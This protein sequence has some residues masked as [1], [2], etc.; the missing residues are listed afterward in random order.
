MV[1]R[2]GCCSPWP[3]HAQSVFSHVIEGSKIEIPYIW[4]CTRFCLHYE[5]PARVAAALLLTGAELMLFS[6][7]DKLVR[8]SDTRIVRL[9]S[10]IGAVGN[11]LSSY[12]EGRKKISVVLWDHNAAA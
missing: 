5:T 9:L 10:A 7:L 12:G 3:L 11:I 8:V 2:C 6:G 4:E 1:D